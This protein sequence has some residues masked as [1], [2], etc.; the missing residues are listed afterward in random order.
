MRAERKYTKEQS[1]GREAGFSIIELMIAM[2][3]TLIVMTA[4]TTLL[5]S[6][7]RIRVR[8]NQK[9]DALADAQRALNIMSRD[10]AN[11]GFG[12]DYNGI[13]IADSGQTAIRVRANVL[14]VNSAATDGQDE[15]VMYVF[16]NSNAIVRYDP[17][18]S[19]TTVSLA[20]RINSLQIQYYDYSYNSAGTLVT[21]GP[22]TAPTTNTGRVRITVGVTLDAVGNQPAAQVQLTSDVTLRNSPF[23]LGRY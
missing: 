8:E 19:P 5:S 2:A 1:A 6:S 15:D 12:L 23:M 11:S 10:I 20:S 22:N 18:A 21:S 16:Q 13:V 7:L 9:S 3:V 14:N 4:A 17:A